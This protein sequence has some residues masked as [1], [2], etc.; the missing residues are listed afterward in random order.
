MHQKQVFTN[1]FWLLVICLLNHIFISCEK[2]VTVDEP[3]NRLTSELV[4]TSDKSA[5]SAIAGLYSKILSS[6]SFANSGMTVYAGMSADEIINTI[7]GTNDEFSKNNLS[8]SNSVI[9]NNFWANG[10]NYIYQV[11]AII[12]GLNTARGVTDAV[13]SQLMGEAKFLRAFI[14]F[15]L[16]NVFGDVPLI[17]ITSF[18]ENSLASRSSHSDIYNQII[19]DLK[20]AQNLLGTNYPTSGRVRPNKWTATALLAR[21]YL[22][23]G[24]YPNAEIEST[25]IINS[26]MYSLSSNL[27]NVFLGGSN[28]AIWQLMPNSNVTAN[29]QNVYEGNLFIPPSG[30]V[31]SYSITSHLLNSFETGDQR[32]I[33][34]VG[35]ISVNATFYYYPYK[36]KVRT[37]A[38][39][40]EYYMVFRLAEQYLIR[41][42]ARAQQNKLSLSEADVNTIRTRAGLSPISMTTQI[43]LLNAILHERQIELF[44]EWGHRFLDLK[45]TQKADIVLG[46]IK[47][48]NWQSTDAL[49]PIPQSQINLNPNLTQNPGY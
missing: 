40:T 17:T 36:Y 4:F 47:S 7:S 10:Y 2:L 23:E 44:A 1:K 20:S 16:T 48:P 8:V 32:R 25:A 33:S 46:A 27:N 22:Y 15:Y 28:E 49:Y 37:A 30:T 39:I 18:D 11:N 34:W 26:G 38:S 24:D 13:K 9:A 35:T 5:T 31:P 41:A 43:G 6:T 45:R 12:E 19:N 29:T 42:E 3:I 21:V 14:Y